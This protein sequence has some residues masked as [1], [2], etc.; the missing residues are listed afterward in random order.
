VKQ[1]GDR[2][3]EDEIRAGWQ[4]ALARLAALVEAG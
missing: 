1:S 3:A 4:S 2:S